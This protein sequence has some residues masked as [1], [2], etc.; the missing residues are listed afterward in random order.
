MDNEN[1]LELKGLKVTFPLE[2]ELVHAVNGVDL[3][4]KKGESIGIVG[5]SG[6]GKSVTF[7]TVIRLVKSPPAIIEGEVILNGRNIMN[8]SEKKMQQVRGKEISMVFQEP[9]RSL[10]PVMRIGDQ[11]AETLILHE[12]LTRRQA[13][14]K[15]LELLKLVEIPDPEDRLQCYPHQ[16]SGGLRQRV[17][18]AMALACD[19]QVLLADEPTTALDVTIQ[20]Q[21]LDLIKRLQREKSMSIV[22]ITHDLGIVADIVDTVA[23][24]YAGRIVEKADKR[25]VFK[26]PLHPYT[27]GLLN[28]VPTL[29]TTAKRLYVIEGSTPDPA[30]LPEVCS[31]CERCKYAQELC[32]TRAPE[33]RDM[34]GGHL[35]ACHRAGQIKATPHNSG[36]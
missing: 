4:L 27:V 7:S 14:A 20:A 21:I 13:K 30:N 23:V 26:N 19:P 32:R 12:Q 17:M 25:S 22:F 10:N 33:L 9:M 2:G 3:T 34:G 24:F 6:C 35:C 15:A 5:E 11:I 8:L 16:L 36:A 31:F 18:I 1:I 29:N 28:C